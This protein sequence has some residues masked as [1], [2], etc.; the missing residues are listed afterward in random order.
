MTAPGSTAPSN[1]TIARALD[2][3]ADLLG[4]QHANLFRVRAWQHAASVVRDSDVSV[5]GLV[6]SK[7]AIP[8]V[9]AS[10]RSA[11]R[12]HERGKTR[13]WV[14]IYWDGEHGTEGRCTVVTETYGPMREHRVVRGHEHE[15]HALD[16]TTGATAG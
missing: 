15:G 10:L 13:D 16:A 6:E 5:A 2:A 1:V 4:V 8:G 9:G 12:A 3:V 14:V 7:A 11:I